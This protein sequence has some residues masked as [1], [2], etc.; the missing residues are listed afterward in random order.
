MSAGILNV[1]NFHSKETLFDIKRDFFTENGD[2]L[3]K[4]FTVVTSL[5]NEFHYNWNFNYTVGPLR[6]NVNNDEASMDVDEYFF[7]ILRI[8]VS[9][10]QRLMDGF[11]AIVEIKINKFFYMNVRFD[12]ELPY[13]E[14]DNRDFL[15]KKL[16]DMCMN[17]KITIFR[18]S[19]IDS[20]LDNYKKFLDDKSLC[21][22]KFDWG[23]T[24]IPAH[25]QL[26]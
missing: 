11:D 26:I 18:R 2:F 7:K 25:E 5:D 12:P 19:H 8:E 24:T 6:K 15:F 23:D 16:D 1:R 22:V 13:R 14:V 10:K 3:P 4:K 21:T 17:I 9:L 20:I